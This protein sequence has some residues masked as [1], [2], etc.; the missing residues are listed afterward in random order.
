[1]KEKC[2]M[3]EIASKY[4]HTLL[5]DISKVCFI[6]TKTRAKITEPLNSKFDNGIMFLITVYK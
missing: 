5:E 6:K 2:Y 1:M 4:E 3:V